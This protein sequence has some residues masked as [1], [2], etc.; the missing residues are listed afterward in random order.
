MEIQTSHLDHHDAQ[1]PTEMTSNYRSN[2]DTSRPFRSVK[3]AV[4]IFG[5]RFLAGEIYAPKTFSFPKPETPV[6]FY[7]PSPSPQNSQEIVSWRSIDSSSNDNSNLAQTLRKLE[8]ELEETKLELKKLKDRESETEVALASLNAE[9]HKNMSKL[10]QAEA[11][12]AG[13]AAMTPRISAVPENRNRGLGHNKQ[14]G[15]HGISE[16]D[17]RRDMIVRLES[18]PTLAQ[19]LNTA[20]DKDG[21][22]EANFKVNNKEKRVKKKPIIPL[23]GDLFSKKKG[24]STSVIN[25]LYAASHLRLN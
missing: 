2:V 14:Q 23:V 9:L 15:D 16:D 11:A 18:S 7:T 20:A 1:T 4:A 25:P 8:T 12:A 19:M 17:R 24:S 3:E 13:K 22:F 21:W 10:A 5:E 6:C